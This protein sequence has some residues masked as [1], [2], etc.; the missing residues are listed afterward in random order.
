MNLNKV[1]R[2]MP[3]ILAGLIVILVCLIVI[4][5][6]ENSDKNNEENSGSGE[7]TEKLA[8]DDKNKIN[9]NNESEKNDSKNNTSEKPSPTPDAQDNP[10]TKEPDT[11]DPD[12]TDTDNNG[13]KDTDNRDDLE[14]GLV[15]T[16]K[17]DFVETKAGVNLRE[18]P[19][20][21]DGIKIVAH[22]E[23]SKVLERTGYNAEWTRVIYNEMECYIATRLI[24]SEMATNNPQD[25]Q[26]TAQNND[27]GFTFE[28]KSDYVSTKDDVNLREAAST[29]STLVANLPKSQRLKRVGYN[30]EWTKVEYDGKICYIA[31]RLITGVY[32]SADD[33]APQNGLADGPE[34]NNGK[35]A[36]GTGTG[37]NTSSTKIVCIDPGHQIKGNYDTE[38]VAPGSSEKK[39]KVSSGTSGIVSGLNE[40]ELNLAVSLQ[41]KDELVSRGY[42]VIMTRTSNE[43]DISNIERAEIANENNADVF[44]RV[45]ANG[46]D[47]K[48]IY[49]IETICPTKSNQY[50]SG[51]YKE[52]RAL[53]DYVLDGMVASTGGKKRYVWET[54]TMSGINWSKVPVTI[55]E[56]GYMTNADEDKKMADADYQE[57]I[58]EGIANG[59]DKYFENY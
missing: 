46:N 56:M 39:A 2:I 7:K 42:T 12:N 23:Q 10:D 5:S 21:E 31:T 40:Y 8:E 59:I 35:E 9:N 27:R 44:I 57:K 26:N 16:E 32:N 30:A 17:Q 3:F 28:E 6:I 36:D 48:S 25:N 14:M 43:V 19:S 55:V 18:R 11:T 53:S 4:G 54:D 58:V 13:Q 49:G 34:Q 52:C 1:L 50:L 47:D 37:K 24:K 20:S 33:T 51:I 15:F 22:L 41:L 29:E 45:H 38:P